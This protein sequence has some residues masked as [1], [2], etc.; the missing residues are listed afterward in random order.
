MSCF[1]RP[2]N[3]SSQLQASSDVAADA[4]DDVAAAVTDDFR[5]LAELSAAVY[6]DE[7]FYRSECSFPG[8]RAP[9][10]FCDFFRNLFCRD[11]LV[12]SARR[13]SSCADS[14][15]PEMISRLFRRRRTVS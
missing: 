7:Y 11:D 3:Y 14:H 10:S 6:F 12:S 13:C 4:A 1:S 2:G 5:F 8:T 15:E 9:L